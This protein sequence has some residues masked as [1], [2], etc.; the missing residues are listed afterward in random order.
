MS[1][2]PGGSP[3]NSADQE[4]SLAAPL[5]ARVQRAADAG[6]GLWPEAG[7]FLAAARH[8]AER[9]GE[10]AQGRVAGQR[11]E[12]R[13]RLDQLVGLGSRPPWSGR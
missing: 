6:Q 9:A 1:R 2:T 4:K 12:E 5:L 7:G 11:A 8:Q 13:L 10:T 3:E